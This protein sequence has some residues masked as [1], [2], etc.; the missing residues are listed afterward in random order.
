MALT[1]QQRIA[2]QELLLQREALYA[3]VHAIE[4]EINEIF[5]DTYPLPPPDV[6]VAQPGVKRKPATSPKSKPSKAKPSR[7]RP[8]E[9]KEKAYRV[10]YQEDSGVADEIHTDRKAVDALLQSPLTQTMLRSV[11]TIDEQGSVQ[12]ILFP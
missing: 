3:R 8:L 2:L 9:T 12:E 4:T 6:D 11:E 5:G 7:L 10:R 1:A